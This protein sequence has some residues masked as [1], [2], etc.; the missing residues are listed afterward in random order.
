MVFSNIRLKSSNF[1]LA[2]SQQEDSTI[3]KSHKLHD[4]R[5]FSVLEI[6]VS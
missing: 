3:S 6:K 2:D 5:G 1:V 4:L